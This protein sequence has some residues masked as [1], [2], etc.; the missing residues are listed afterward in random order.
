MDSKEYCLALNLD[1]TLSFIAYTLS[2]LEGFLKYLLQFAHLT[3]SFYFLTYN[4]ETFRSNIFSSS[5]IRRIIPLDG[6]SVYSS[7]DT[8]IFQPQYF[9][10]L[11]ALRLSSTVSYFIAVMDL[12]F[13]RFLLHIDYLSFFKHIYR[14]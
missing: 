10:D 13:L 12:F 5:D 11:I 9:H 1:D 14:Q 4:F 6:M 8:G 7:L 3:H 2:I